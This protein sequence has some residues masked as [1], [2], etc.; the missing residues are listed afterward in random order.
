MFSE[1]IL[2]GRIGR[3]AEVRTL[4]SSGGKVMNFT[5]ATSERWKDR[6]SGERK[7]RTEWHQVVTM[8]ERM[9]D[10]IESMLRKGTLVLVRGKLQTRK[11][12]DQ[13]GQERVAHEIMIGPDGSVQ[14][15]SSPREDGASDGQ[16]DEQRPARS[17]RPARQAAQVED[18][19]IPF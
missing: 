12:T 19:Q 13:Q 10:A 5:V 15:L 3:D 2:V 9:I 18:D 7:E 16:G 17:S 14:I 11:W 6:T 8:N 1:T 4:H